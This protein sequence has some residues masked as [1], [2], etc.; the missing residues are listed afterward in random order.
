MFLLTIVLVERDHVIVKRACQVF[1]I[2]GWIA[3]PFL[4]RE[5][6]KFR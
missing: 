5:A 2:F 1:V 3:L 4:I 6:W